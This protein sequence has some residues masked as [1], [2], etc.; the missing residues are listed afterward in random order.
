MISFV[1][2]FVWLLAAMVLLVILM[3]AL[4]PAQWLAGV[5]QQV[6]NGRALPL[7]V[8][9]VWWRGQMRVALADKANE[10]TPPTLLPGVL[11]WRLAGGSLSP[12]AA[13]LEVSAPAL[14]PAPMTLTLSPIGLSGAKISA[15]AWKTQMPLGLL[16]GL[17]APWNTLGLVG[18]LY[19][20]HEEVLIESTTSAT[21]FRGNGKL[22]ASELQ[23]SLSPLKP[24]GSYRMQWNGEPSGGVKFTLATDQGPLILDGNGDF[25]NGKARFDGTAQAAPGAEGALSSLLAVIGRREAGSAVVRIRVQ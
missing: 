9:G 25:L 7:E 24:L 6:S 11:S 19:W 14:A 15:S 3:L 5:I 13:M 12:L 23:S 4:A 10:R 17:G 21:N 8:H 22:L 16:E 18:L 1:R 20:Q 2:R